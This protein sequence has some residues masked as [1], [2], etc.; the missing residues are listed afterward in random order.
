MSREVII[1]DSQ[2]MTRYGMEALI[3]SDFQGQLGPI[4]SVSSKNDLIRALMATPEGVVVLDYTLSD[5]NSADALLNTHARFQRVQWILFS[6]ELSVQFLR[7]VALSY[8][9]FSVVLKSADLV[10]VKSA[11]SAA[12]ERSQFLCSEVRSLLAGT[13]SSL[14]Q[15]TDPLTLTEKEILKEIAWGATAKE[16]AQRRN[17]SFYTVITHR[18]NIYRKLNVNNS[19][20][21]SRYALRS[22]L[23]EASDYFI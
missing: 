19:Q 1:Y 14:G 21:A 16:I 12:L 7:K 22:G 23:I 3:H 11:L 8:P 4:T 13:D 17:I 10:A 18:K 20:E 15:E 9:S 5:Y 2:G 6:N